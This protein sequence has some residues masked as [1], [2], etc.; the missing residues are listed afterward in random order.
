MLGG[1]L[2]RARA[3]SLIGTCPLISRCSLLHSCKNRRCSFCSLYDVRRRN[4]LWRFGSGRCVQEQTSGVLSLVAFWRPVLALALT[5]FVEHGLWVVAIELFDP[6]L[7]LCLRSDLV[8][9]PLRVAAVHPS[10][11]FQPM[12]AVV[13]LEQELAV[14]DL[15]LVPVSVL[16]R[17]WLGS[18]L[19]RL[20]AVAVPWGP[21]G[22]Q[23]RVVPCHWPGLPNSDSCDTRFCPG[24]FRRISPGC[25]CSRAAPVPFCIVSVSYRFLSLSSVSWLFPQLLWSLPSLVLR[26]LQLPSW[27][28]WQLALRPH[29]LPSWP[30]RLPSWP[31]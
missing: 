2:C 1:I 22:W 15:D 19:L 18:S 25:W 28:L 16:S 8:A 27:S 20:R 29:P 4:G 24:T 11:L 23:L 14:S 6:S 12:L 10:P 21:F 9:M 31:R 3:P 26:P 13:D 7:P 17:G 5:P 30:H